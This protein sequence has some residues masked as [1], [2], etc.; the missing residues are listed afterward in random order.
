MT[1]KEAA[2]VERIIDQLIDAVK[3]GTTTSGDPCELE[4]TRKALD[5]I[6][7]AQSYKKAMLTV[8]A[9]KRAG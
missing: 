4:Y 8:A 6:K 7:E 5:A 1:P 9:L 3:N 2:Q